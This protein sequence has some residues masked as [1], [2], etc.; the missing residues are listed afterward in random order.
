S[1]TTTSPPPSSTTTTSPPPSST[2][3]TTT[4]PPP[5]RLLGPGDTGLAVLQLQQRLSALG[6][7]LGVPDGVFGDSTEQA[8]YALQKAAGIVRDGIVGPVTEA[9]LARGVVPQPRPARGHVVEIDLQRDLLMIVNNGKL[10]AVLNTST[11]GGYTYVDDGVTAVANTPVGVF[12]IYREVDG[13]VIDS[14][15]ELWRPKY[16]DDGFAIHGDSYVPPEP[17][18]HGCVRVS[19]EAIDWIWAENLLPIGTEV[20]IY[21]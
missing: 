18:S 12:R 14:L 2:T 16:F 1:T 3:T 9:A 5:V 4:P 17:V 11:G 13:L 10:Y 15:G 8:V 20:W 19:N 7:W 6:Y 21:Y